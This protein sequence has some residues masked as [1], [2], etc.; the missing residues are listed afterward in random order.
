[1]HNDDVVDR[2]CRNSMSKASQK[3]EEN[4]Q[5]QL[6]FRI[7]EEEIIIPELP[8]IPSNPLQTNQIKITHIDYNPDGS[9]K[10]NETITLLLLS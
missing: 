9:D 3:D 10:D 1:M 7:D 6:S 2:Y 4:I 5:N 8:E